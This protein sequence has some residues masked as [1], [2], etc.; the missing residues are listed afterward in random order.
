MVQ[1]MWKLRPGE[2]RKEARQVEASEHVH[3]ALVSQSHKK[4]NVIIEILNK[5]YRIHHNDNDKY[6]LT[7]VMSTASLDR[8]LDS[9]L[10]ES[11]DDVAMIAFSW[12]RF[13]NEEKCV[14]PNHHVS[15]HQSHPSGQ[16]G[17]YRLQ[18]VENADVQG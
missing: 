10:P 7:H 3:L 1:L 18:W 16:G 11:R 12:T 15:S 13:N 8:R 4:K 9:G 17:E 6:N 5:A 2:W 14:F